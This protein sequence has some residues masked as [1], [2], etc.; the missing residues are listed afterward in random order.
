[1]ENVTRGSN[2]QRLPLYEP[3]ERAAK[4]MVGQ[5][6]ND[7]MNQEPLED[8]DFKSDV[9]SEQEASEKPADSVQQE[10]QTS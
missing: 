4:T 5:D 2:N 1:M 7:V 6:I 3:N 10:K 8:H 9:G